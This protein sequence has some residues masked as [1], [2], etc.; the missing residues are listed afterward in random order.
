VKTKK[1]EI[2]LEKSWT[3]CGNSLK[4]ESIVRQEKRWFSLRQ[5]GVKTAGEEIAKGG[6]RRKVEETTDTPE[7]KNKGKG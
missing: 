2:D 3:A 4:R 7:E 6:H 5:V 1:G